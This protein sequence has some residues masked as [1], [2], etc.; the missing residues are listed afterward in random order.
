MMLQLLL[1]QNLQV[2]SSEG[3]VTTLQDL[4]APGAPYS[5]VEAGTHTL[6]TLR[7]DTVDSHGELR[8]S[9]EK[10]KPVLER[11]E[12]LVGMAKVQFAKL[13]NQQTP[14]LLSK[15]KEGML[16]FRDVELTLNQK[17]NDLQGTYHEDQ[18]LMSARQSIATAHFFSHSQ[19]TYMSKEMHRSNDEITLG[20]HP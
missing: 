14:T 6:K 8:D 13:Y 17:T 20:M 4:N 12:Q 9:M 15:P 1:S 2:E 16:R 7:E 3:K 11:S 10:I 19:N 5:D 18:T